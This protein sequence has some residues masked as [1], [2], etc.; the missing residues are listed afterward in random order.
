MGQTGS[1]ADRIK[2]LPGNGVRKDVKLRMSR[3]TTGNQRRIFQGLLKRRHLSIKEE[4]MRKSFK[5][6]MSIAVLMAMTLGMI[7]CGRTPSDSS[8]ASNKGSSDAAVNNDSK[9]YKIIIADEDNEER[10]TNQCALKFKERVEKESN[11]RLVVELHCNGELGGDQETFEGMQLGTIQMVMCGAAALG[12]YDAR[13]GMLDFPFLFDNYEEMTAAVTGEL[14]ELYDSVAQEYGFKVLGWMYDGARSISNNVRPINSLEDVKGLKMRV[15]QNDMY[16]SM[17]KAWGTNPTPMSATEI[18]TALSQGVI[19]GQDNPPSLGY[20]QKYYEVQKYYSWTR[21]TFQNCIVVTTMDW[22]N[23]LPD[24]LRKIVEDAAKDMAAEQ[25]IMEH[26]NEAEL[27]K[28]IDASG[29]CTTNEVAD[30]ESFKAASTPVYEEMR[31]RMG[32]DFV[33][34]VLKAAGRE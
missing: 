5:M 1:Y 4:T 17:F 3:F 27:E 13:F 10:T 29:T 21:H 6:A 24:D 2:Q 28:L 23:S 31:E 25:R 20:S 11:G 30:R 26:D 9:I 33:D 19:D 7:G 18:Y 14:G 15:M 16:I 32:S 8:S 12:N 34:Q 22:L